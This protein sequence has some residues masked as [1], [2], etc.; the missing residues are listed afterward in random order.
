MTDKLN[1]ILAVLKAEVAAG[2]GDE[3]VFPRDTPDT[4][5]TVIDGFEVEVTSRYNDEGRVECFINK[6]SRGSSLAVVEDFGAIIPYD[7]SSEVKVKDATIGRIR[8]FAEKHG[9]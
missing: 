5:N 6:G 7:E 8:A 9:Y 2:K 3:P 4:V 1:Q